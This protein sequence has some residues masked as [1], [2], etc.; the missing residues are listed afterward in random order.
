MIEQESGIDVEKFIDINQVSE[1]ISLDNE[2]EVLETGSIPFVGTTEPIKPLQVLELDAA[3]TTMAAKRLKQLDD[4]KTVEEYGRYYDMYVNGQEDQIRMELLSL[5]M[6]RR[7]AVKDD[8]VFKSVMEGDKEAAEA[9]LDVDIGFDPE[10]EKFVIIEREA[11]EQVIAEGANDEDVAVHQLQDATKDVSIN[12]IHA[13]LLTSKLLLNKEITYF[14]SKMGWNMSTLADFGLIT[15]PFS[16]SVS[17]SQKIA[18]EEN[19]ILPGNDM[20]SQAFAF[21]VMSPTQQAE[22][23]QRLRTFFDKDDPSFYEMYD[24]SNNNLVA[25]TYFSHLQHMSDGEKFLENYVI[26]TLDSL[27]LAGPLL[28]IAQGVGLLAQTS[29]K[30]AKALTSGDTASISIMMGSRSA[31]TKT[32]VDAVIAARSGDIVKDSPDAIKAA[33]T[34][35]EGTLKPDPSIVGGTPGVSER[36]VESLKE[37]EELGNAF[38]ATRVL[39]LLSPADLLSFAPAMRQQVY[40]VFREMNPGLVDTIKMIGGPANVGQITQGYGKGVSFRS[41]WGSGEGKGFASIEAAEGAI[42]ELKLDGAIITPIEVNKTFFISVDRQVNNLAGFIDPYKLV[43]KE[44]ITKASY[45]GLGG[46]RRV[47]GTPTAFVDTLSAREV[48]TTLSVKENATRIYRGLQKHIDKVSKDEMVGLGEVMQ[49]GKE[50]TQWFSDDILKIRFQLND[51]QIVAYNAFKKV[52]KINYNILNSRTYDIKAAKGFKTIETSEGVRKLGFGSTFDAVPVSTISNPKNKTVYNVTTG[53]FEEGLTPA[54]LKAYKDKGFSVLSLEKTEELEEIG[55]AQYLIGSYSDLKIKPLNYNQVEKLAGGRL[56]YKEGWFIKQARIRER[57][58]L[59][60]IVLKSKTLRVDNKENAAEFIR[61]TNA[62]LKL[63][64]TLTVKD[65]ALVTDEIINASIHAASEGLFKDGDE[66]VKFIGIKNLRVD[67]EMVQDGA[68][69]SAVRKAMV[70]GANAHPSDLDE[71]NSIQRLIQTRGSQLSKRGPA[72]LGVD[73]REAATLHPAESA[74]KSLERS[75]KMISMGTWKERHINKFHKT[76][77]TVLQDYNKKTPRDHFLNPEFIVKP[78]KEEA[79]LI[80][81]AKRM[82]THY[83]TVLNTPTWGDRAVKDLMYGMAEV[84]ESSFK[85]VGKPIKDSSLEGIRNFNPVNFLTHSTYHAFMGMFNIRQP[86]IQIQATA[87]MISA[88]PVNGARAATLAAP[89]RIMLLS[90]NA[91]TL[92]SLA[93]GAGAVVG[94]KADDVKEIYTVLQKAG[95]WRMGAG[96]LVEQVEQ[97]LSSSSVGGKILKVGEMPFLETERFNKIAATISATLDWKAANKGVKIGDEAIK[98]IVLKAEAYVAHMNNLDKANYQSGVMKAGVQFWGY[99]GRAMEMFLPEFMGGSKYFT[100]GQKFRMSLSQL[101]MYGVGGT[102]SPSR[103]LKFREGFNEMYNEKFGENAPEAILDVMDRGMIETMLASALGVDVSFANKGGL[104]LSTSGLGELATKIAYLDFA[105]IQK[106]DAASLSVLGNLLPNVYAMVKL[107]TDSDVTSEQGVT[108]FLAMGRKTLRESVSAFGTY[109]QAFLSL[110]TNNMMNRRGQITDKSTSNLEVLLNTFGLKVE[111]SEV[112]RAMKDYLFEDNKTAKAY[113]DV[114]TRALK[115][116]SA[117]DNYTTYQELVTYF[118]G[119][120]AEDKEGLDT[121]FKRL[122]QNLKD[123]SSRIS[124][125]FWKKTQRYID[126]NEE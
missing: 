83:A 102:I 25:L 77:G 20:A 122:R 44:G 97:G 50:T 72:Q 42:A 8:L 82:Q 115:V 88:N 92:S 70:E 121:M 39:D 29:A 34:A 90:D 52:D 74:S 35:M 85:T 46:L 17:T 3:V 95:T 56:D 22:T 89:M 71:A 53:V 2:P 84:V 79:T 99:Q 91:S 81:Q 37:I 57:D 76:F 60:S 24:G 6:G 51:T 27:V 69:L 105:E 107:F 58:G 55:Y 12:D 63:A 125:K 11:A 30:V 59:P 62:A 73:G 7:Q 120:Y 32:T 49:Y 124:L 38:E 31:A 68:E 75:L 80:E 14:G 117:T 94:L 108:A 9:L 61:K 43:G 96:Q 103:G 110:Q 48:Y 16:S 112:K 54:K 123:D 66:L 40:D 104:G 106:I 98:D 21:Q 118:S 109:E 1:G 5:K 87:L 10:K 45:A 111:N 15:I 116:A 13:E 113:G 41:F 93:R 119:I 114:L 100:T 33:E 86:L 126:L 101:G 19:P 18:T 26:P 78:S 28:K 4:T 67:I 23:L 47:F 65:G 64:R 36:V